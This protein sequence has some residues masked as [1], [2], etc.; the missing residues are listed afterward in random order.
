MRRSP[1]SHAGRIL[2]LGAWSLSAIACAEPPT[3]V[4]V[5]L[6]ADDG[7]L[8]QSITVEVRACTDFDNDPETCGERYR[9]ERR[10]DAAPPPIPGRVPIGP[11]RDVNATFWL[12]ATLRTEA[13]TDRVT[14]RVWGTYLRGRTREVTLRLEASCVEVECGPFETCSA[15][16]CVDA[17]VED[18]CR[19]PDAG[20][21]DA[22]EPVVD[23]GSGV[24]AGCSC[25][26]PSDSCVGGE[27]RP[28]RPADD[29]TAGQYH[30]LALLDGQLVGWGENTL[31]QLGLGASQEGMIFDTPIAI[32][33][34]AR[35]FQVSTGVD[36]TCA[37]LEPGSL[38]CWGDS[39]SHRLGLTGAYDRTVP[40]EVGTEATWSRVTVNARHACATTTAGDAYCWGRALE[41][42]IGIFEPPTTP[43]L[44]VDTPTRVASFMDVSVGANHTCAITSAGN[45]RCWGANGDG[46]AG[47]DR[48]TTPNVFSPTSLGG[49]RYAS[50]D[51]GDNQACAIDDAGSMRCWG[52]NR[53]D[54]LG[55][56]PGRGADVS[57]PTPVMTSEL[58]AHVSAGGL[59]QCGVTLEGHLY[60]WGLNLN[61]QLGVGD[62]TTHVEPTEV[63]PSGGWASVSAGRFHTCA[64]R[65]DGTVYCWGRGMAG[66]LSASCGRG[67]RST[68]CRV[69]I[70]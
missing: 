16:R 24:D 43:P 47:Q 3:Q 29:V 63:L 20:V 2:A 62:A 27:C 8:A 38:Y 51:A 12:E 67:D 46:Q 17:C 4:I 25:P 65:V 6:E 19:G 37:I 66:Q 15:G 36:S 30:S 45:L 56:G 11:P 23:A 35:V 14:G 7:A 64:V 1:R 44:T 33:T 21:R 18:D 48:S 22:G 53:D 68:P 50:L 9:Q 26:C 13:G 59:H 58:F 55:I 39:T 10:L 40:S 34:P 41:G 70:D 31:S 5:S 69:C 57:S 54:R 32:P 49:G 52:D 28:A 61:G 42:Q 60:C